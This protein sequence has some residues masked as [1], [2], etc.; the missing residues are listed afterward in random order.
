MI[1]EWAGSLATQGLNA[2]GLR[3]STG[4]DPGI[5]AEEKILRQGFRRIAD[6]NDRSE[7]ECPLSGRPDVA[8]ILV[9]DG[10]AD[11]RE[12]AR[13]LF[14]RE[15]HEVLES[16][17]GLAGLQRAVEDAPDL[18]LLDLD[19]PGLGGDDICRRLRSEERT[20]G[21]PVV[22]WSSSLDPEGHARAIEAGAEAF[23]TRSFRFEDLL[24]NVRRLLDESSSDWSPMMI[25]IGDDVDRSVR[26]PLVRPVDG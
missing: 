19:L 17:D 9:V 22:I 3:G 11:F 12:I 2:V 4:L 7:G 5:L 18:I 13:S 16:R 10:N 23:V 8:R 20:M 26:G 6:E 24:E 14:E 25:S 1:S 15:A 21:I